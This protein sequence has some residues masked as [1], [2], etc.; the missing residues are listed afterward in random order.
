MQ[1]DLSQFVLESPDTL[2]FPLVR[3]EIELLYDNPVAF[4]AYIKVWYDGVNLKDQPYTKLYQ[5]QLKKLKQNDQDWLWH[6]FWVVLSVKDRTIVGFMNFDKK[7][8]NTT[9][10]INFEFNQ[11]YL[12]DGFVTKGLALLSRWTMGQGINKVVVK[13]DDNQTYK[14]DILQECGFTKT[15]NQTKQVYQLKLSK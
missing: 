1:Q 11:K 15:Q 8:T 14:T 6:T 5:K 3:Q 10:Q 4:S 13:L 7:P 9:C 2:V 12:Q